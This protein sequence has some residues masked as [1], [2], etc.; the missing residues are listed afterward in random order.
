MRRAKGTEWCVLRSSNNYPL[1]CLKKKKSLW[2][3]PSKNNPNFLFSKLSQSFK[4]PQFKS[5]PTSLCFLPQKAKPAYFWMT[6]RTISNHI[7]SFSVHQRMSAGA[8]S[9]LMDV[10]DSVVTSE[11]RWVRGSGEK[12]MRMRSPSINKFFRP[13]LCSSHLSCLNLFLSHLSL[14]RTLCKNPLSLVI[15]PNM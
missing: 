14:P 3:K 12:F 11:G 15:S 4:L 7:I 8:C 13:V 9:S 5:L 2:V 10:W 6:L 1:P